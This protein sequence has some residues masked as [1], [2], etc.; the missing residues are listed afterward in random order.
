MAA[1]SLVPT[2][3][4]T[5]S[6]SLGILLLQSV[7]NFLINSYISS[8]TLRSHVVSSFR[9]KNVISNSETTVERPLNIYPAL[10]VTMVNDYKHL[11]SCNPGVA[12]AILTFEVSKDPTNIQM[13]DSRCETTKL[14]YDIGSPKLVC[15]NDFGFRTLQCIA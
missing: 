12:R 5:L 11:P 8:A 2:I 13:P 15:D 6:H 7:L 1:A 10:L 14:V 3:T 9:D 4:A